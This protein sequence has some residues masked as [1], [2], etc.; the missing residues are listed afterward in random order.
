MKTVLIIGLLLSFA[1]HAQSASPGSS[2]DYKKVEIA[3]R[4]LAFDYPNNAS[5]FELG[6]NDQGVKILGLKLGTGAIKNLIVGTHHGNEYG[7][8][9][10]ALGAAADLAARPIQGRTIYVIPV[11]NVSGFEADSRNETNASGVSVDANRDYPGPCGTEGPYRLKS[12]HALAEFIDREGIVS[13]ATL[14]TSGGL[15]LYPWGIST[16]DLST[17]YDSLFIDLGRMCAVAS[18]YAVGNSTQLLYPADGAFEDY[19]F[20][21]HG[22]WSI[23][24]EIGETHSPDSVQ[25]AQIVRENVPGLRKFMED[26]PVSRAVDHDFKGRC[27][28]NLL[29]RDRHDE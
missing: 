2:Q 3:M 24:F 11:L 19:A 23:L 10:V 15:I 29:K 21:K 8:T 1:A 26:A 20:W 25:V 14:H 16:Q 9:E 5:V 28:T 12:T 6:A 4:Q 27:E 17:P 18:Q 13:S 7:S 22:I